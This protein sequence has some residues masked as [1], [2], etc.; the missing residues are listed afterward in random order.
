MRLI[1]LFYFISSISFSQFENTF[2]KL[3]TTDTAVGHDKKYV[4]GLGSKNYTTKWIYPNTRGQVEKY[5]R[6]EFAISMPRS[7]D[8]KVKHFLATDDS[9]EGINPFLS[10][11][12][13]VTA[14]F[15]HVASNKEF[16]ID[17][18]YYQ[19]FK[20]DTSHSDF[21]K[22]EWIPLET[23]DYFRVRFAPSIAGQWVCEINIH[24]KNQT[25]ENY[26]NF[27]FTV[28][29]S[30]NKGFVK[31]G[32]NKRYLVEGDETFFPAGQN[33]ISPRCEFCYAN[34]NGALPS[35]LGRPGAQSFEGWMEKPTAMKGFLMFQED[36]TNL[37]KSGGNYFREIL[38]PQNQDIEWEKL[39]NYYG[40]MNRAW[41]LDEQLFLAREL[42]LKIQLNLQ[43]QYALQIDN[44][45]TFWNWSI[46]ANDKRHI[47]PDLP[48]ANPYNVGISTTKNDDPN[49]FFSDPTAKKFYKEK[50]RYIFSRWGYSTNLAVIG[51]VSE[52][53][54]CCT[55]A[56]LCVKWMD[57]MGRYLKE[58]LKINQI[59]IPSFLGIF[60]DPKN[61]ENPILANPIYDMSAYNWYAASAKKFQGNIKHI[62]GLIT[63]FGQP[64]FYGEIGNANLYP[65][66]T[67]RVEWGRDC[68][69]TAFSG[70]AG[71]GMN[72]DDSFDDDLRQYLGNIHEF[73]NGINFDGDTAAWL[74]TRVISDNRKAETMLLIS[75]DKSAAIGILSNRYYNWYLFGDTLGTL[76][77]R[78][79]LCQNR[80]PFDPGF[81]PNKPIEEKGV[82]EREFKDSP[83]DYID[84]VSNTKM[85]QAVIYH[86]FE[87]FSHNKNKHYRIRLY[88]MQ[89]AY[90]RVD[91]YN[92]F[93]LAPISTEYN[94]GPNLK[95]E[96]PVMDKEAGLIAYKVRKVSLGQF[97][98]INEEDRIPINFSDAIYDE[99]YRYIKI[100]N[101]RYKL[102]INKE[103]YRLS[104]E[105]LNPKEEDNYS[106]VIS[107]ENHSEVHAT[108]Y[109]KASKDIRLKKLS[110]G[111]YTIE[112]KI[113]G[114]IYTEVVEL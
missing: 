92:A 36:M 27:P 80:I 70:N 48:C 9:T 10:W 114:V 110:K 82:W 75:P 15:K 113:N 85:N 23:P 26:A 112:I 94:W 71:I 32:K 88:E 45:R 81:H 51:M 25:F 93:T 107:D 37:S 49:T 105:H 22:W 38:F 98:Q 33:L 18:F 5:E 69:M 41:E 46:D 8:E 111:R 11:Q 74:P 79:D 52:M 21:R 50:L 68:W 3:D 14:R 103:E 19:N 91:F 28:N 77:N 61:Y 43:I 95:V 40:R 2:K 99:D 1:F 56:D 66:D 54:G 64:F 16:F 39:G 86:P 106:L 60:H 97:P 24:T 100:I 109:T 87:S 63:T 4:S 53:E 31:V 101:N 83:H 55:D 108:N 44:S 78:P 30:N 57:E 47:R 65:C 62:D 84:R 90:Y 34:S 29:R 12:L 89:R 59:L 73:V 6:L 17:G 104:I 72:W 13:K 58:D 102:I 96:Y 67:M 7:I 35:E 42:N 76:W 20:R